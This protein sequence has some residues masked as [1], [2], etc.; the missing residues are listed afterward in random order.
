MLGI[1]MLSLHHQLA[2]SAE[3]ETALQLQTTAADLK[4]TPGA[5]AAPVGLDSSSAADSTGGVPTGSGKGQVPSV[6]VAVVGIAGQK[7]QGG[8]V[9]ARHLDAISAPP[10]GNTI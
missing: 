4:M 6:G 7:Q 10:A 9:D 8:G 1:W 2:T 5:A 3:T